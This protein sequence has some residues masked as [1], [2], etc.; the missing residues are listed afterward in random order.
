M[1]F[2]NTKISLV[3]HIIFISYCKNI[4]LND[5]YVIT[6]LQ[7]KEQSLKLWNNIIGKGIFSK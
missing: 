2:K 5:A 6:P 4:S 1:I 3:E 7:G